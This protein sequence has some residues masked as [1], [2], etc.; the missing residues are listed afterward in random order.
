MRIQLM[1]GLYTCI[2]FQLG[3][4]LLRLFKRD[5]WRNRGKIYTLNI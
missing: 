3:K 4:S 1:V 5:Q 2:D